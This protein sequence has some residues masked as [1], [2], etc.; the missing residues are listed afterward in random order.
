MQ[1]RNGADL[2]GQTA[3][4][5]VP[6]EQRPLREYD[7]L[8]RSWFFAWPAA[9]SA[10]LGRALIVSWL[11]VLPLCLLVASGS[12][13]LRHHPAQWVLA[14]AVAALGLP[15]LLLLRQWLGWHY[16]DRRLVAERVAYEESGWYDG[17]EWEKPLA[18]RQQ[19]LL[20]SRHEVRPVLRR[21]REGTVLVLVLLLGGAALC[22]ALQAGWLG[23]GP[24]L[25]RMVP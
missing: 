8:C 9:G 20:V 3:P 18:W 25:A 16:V 4:C 21:L 15:L 24:G 22:Q 2:P 17:Q 12:W 13:S 19:D 14:G 23:L 11:L 1:N 6:V 10:A 5:P 7:Q